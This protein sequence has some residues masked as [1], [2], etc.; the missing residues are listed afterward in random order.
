MKLSEINGKK[1]LETL[2]DLIDPLAAILADGTIRDAINAKE[3]MLSI[4][5]TMLK[6]WPDEIITIL[7]LLDGEDPTQYEVNLLTLPRK[8][9]EVI[10]DKDV[11]MLFFSLEQTEE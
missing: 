11:Q 5:K 4:A 3:P 2:A 9:Y 8:L 6:K 10:N 1:A 7:A